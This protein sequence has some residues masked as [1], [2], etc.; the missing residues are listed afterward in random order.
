[1]AALA[2]VVVALAA[3]P[4]AMASAG[5]VGDAERATERLTGRTDDTP[6]SDG[7][8]K[9]ESGP[10]GAGARDGGTRGDEARGAGA[11]EQ[12]AP[13]GEGRAGGPDAAEQPGGGPDASGSDADGPDV[14]GPGPD[15][16]SAGAVSPGLLDLGLATT[17]RCGS[18][19]SSPGGV[20]AQTCVLRQDDETWARAYYR[21]ATGRRLSSVL[22]LMSPDG[23]SVRMH[24]TVGAQDEPGV[25]ETPKERGKGGLEAYTA[26]AEFATAGP[27]GADTGR[28]PLLLRAGS[29]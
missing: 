15:G 17:A 6:R 10:H 9:R 1:M 11:L 18:A 5:P 14:G 3:L 13:G 8:A 20:E 28:G 12:A 23:R 19:L 4:L 25:C 29:N 16:P 26:V 24:C 7:D 22:S 21:N 2:A 27:D